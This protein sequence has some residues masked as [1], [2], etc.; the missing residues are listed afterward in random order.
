MPAGRGHRR[1][2]GPGI[3]VPL[4]CG[5]QPGRRTRERDLAARPLS[6]RATGE[7]N[8]ERHTAAEK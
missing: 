7:K 1:F 8:E 3:R 6:L 4:D 5:A 2:R